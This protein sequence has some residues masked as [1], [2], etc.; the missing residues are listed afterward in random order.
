MTS[1]LGQIQDT[2][3]SNNLKVKADI[4]HRF[5]RDG[6]YYIVSSGLELGCENRA[7]GLDESQEEFISAPSQSFYMPQLSQLRVMMSDYLLNINSGNRQK[8]CV[9]SYHSLVLH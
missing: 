8:H 7:L 4:K 9:T 2:L 3:L 6:R 1:I 5:L